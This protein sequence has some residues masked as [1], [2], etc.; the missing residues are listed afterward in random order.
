VALVDKASRA[1]DASQGHG[2]V[3]QTLR[4]LEAS[5]QDILVR[6]FT[7]GLTE[8]AGEMIGTEAHLVRQDVEGDIVA[9]MSRN[10]VRYPRRL[11]TRSSAHRTA[12]A[13]SS[14]R[15]PVAHGKPPRPVLPSLLARW[16][17]SGAAPRASPGSLAM[18]G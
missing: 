11:Q 2:L 3:E 15:S 12:P 4:S 7:H 10:E 1:G 18:R 5:T 6:T 9:E 16:R 14:S 8:H 13:R 17:D